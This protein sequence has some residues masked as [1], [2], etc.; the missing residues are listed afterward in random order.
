MAA[1][2]ARG[3][4]L[5]DINRCRFA[6]NLRCGGSGLPGLEP[7]TV[8]DDGGLHAVVDAEL[9]TGV[10]DVRLDRRLADVELARQLG[11]RQ[12]GRQARDDLKPGSK[13]AVDSFITAT[14][15]EYS[16]NLRSLG[17]LRSRGLASMTAQA[18]AER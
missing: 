1:S 2:A 13:V 11:V 18:G 7:S 3:W 5:D 8:G 9:C 16:E 17:T 15:K 12:P 14:V 6:R 10:H 4:P